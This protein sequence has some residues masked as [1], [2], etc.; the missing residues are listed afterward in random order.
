MPSRT[1]LI[2]VAA[3][4]GI[5]L[6]ISGINPHE[7]ST[8][9]MEVAPVLAVFPL[10][11]VTGR[12]FPLTSLLYLLIAAHAAILILGGA[13]TYARVPLGAWVQEW[14][15]LSRN[16]YDKLGHLAQGLVPALAARELF[17]RREVVRG[18]SWIGVLAVAVALSVSL[19][20]ELVE[21][22]A[23]LM[24]G[25]GADAFL[26]MQGDPWDTQSDMGM[27]LLGALCAVV[28]LAGIHDRQL[29]R[30]SRPVSHGEAG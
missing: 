4:V 27:A 6:L 2:P 9:L 23:A 29:A 30:M 3:A 7:R 1:W 20:Y 17:V 12:R 25:Q 28:L 13:Y 18:R 26:G 10:L 16:P 24:L 14:L 11:I 5:A 21:W 8:W 15:D 22:A 19:L